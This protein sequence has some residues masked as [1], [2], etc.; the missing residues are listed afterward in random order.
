MT[1]AI[2]GQLPISWRCLDP[3]VSAVEGKRLNRQA[4]AI[5]ERLRLGP[6]SNTELY[7]LCMNATARIS[8]IRRAGFDIQCYDRCRATGTCWYRVALTVPT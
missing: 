1:D 2:S 8:E 7:R 3:S 4:V 5:L 6:A